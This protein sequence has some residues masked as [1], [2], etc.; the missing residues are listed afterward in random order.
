[1][2]QIKRRRLPESSRAFVEANAFYV[3]NRSYVNGTGG[4]L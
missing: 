3:G 4:S 1:V 2:K